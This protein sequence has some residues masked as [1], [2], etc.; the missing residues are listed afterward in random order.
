MIPAKCCCV[1]QNTCSVFSNARNQISLPDVGVAVQADNDASSPGDEFLSPFKNSPKREKRSESG[2]VDSSDFESYFTDAQMDSAVQIVD[3]GSP[4]KAT[5]SGFMPS[6]TEV[7]SNEKASFL[8]QLFNKLEK[9]EDLTFDQRLAVTGLFSTLAK[10]PHEG[11][12]ERL[13]HPDDSGSSTR[14]LDTILRKLW[15]GM[16][17]RM[18]EIEGM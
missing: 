17:H 10:L 18:D 9:F 3:Y 13:F 16:L 6:R 7:S 14:T 2:P 5:A 8:S 12:H 1:S 11:L 15:A 4:S